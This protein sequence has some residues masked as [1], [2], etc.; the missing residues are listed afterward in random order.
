[1]TMARIQPFCRENLINL[2]YLYGTRVFPRPLTD[3]GNGLFLYNNHFCLK[4]E[5]ENVSF[6][7]AIKKLKDTFKIDDNFKREENVNSHFIYQ[8]IPKKLNLI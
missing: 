7:Q 4:W 6:K 5:S 2:G 3:R 1:M 8:F